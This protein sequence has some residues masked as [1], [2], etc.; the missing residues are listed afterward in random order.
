MKEV[1][2]GGDE[3]KEEVR[4][5]AR[6]G[7]EVVEEVMEA[8]RAGG[9]SEEELAAALQ[10]ADDWDFLDSAAAPSSMPPTAG[11]LTRCRF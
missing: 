2:G 5:L 8:A 3:G 1:G 4:G 7:R 11:A 10:Q 6:L 9:F